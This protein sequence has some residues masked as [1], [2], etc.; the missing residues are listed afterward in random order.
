MVTKPEAQE[1]PKKLVVEDYQDAEKPSPGRRACHRVSPA[2]ATRFKVVFESGPAH[3]RCRVFVGPE[4]GTLALAGS[5]C[6]RLDE[7]VAFA[8]A[9]EAGSCFVEAR[10]KVEIE[11]ADHPRLGRCSLCGARRVANEDGSWGAC[12]GPGCTDAMFDVRREEA[13]RVEV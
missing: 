5:L 12:T 3:V 6:F 1:Q 7:W 11:P 10:P 9:L 4:V 13:E 8:G 2:M